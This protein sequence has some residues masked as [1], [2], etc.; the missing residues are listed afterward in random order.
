M[1]YTMDLYDKTLSD[2]NNASIVWKMELDGK[3]VEDICY[4]NYFRF[5]GKD[6]VPVDRERFEAACRRVRRDI[7]EY[8]T[9]EYYIRGGELIPDL[10]KDPEQKI[11][12]NFC[13]MAIKTLN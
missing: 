1:L 5:I 13:K 4:N 11:A 7:N 9:D 12:Y 3:T 8:P 6:P 2:T 10:K